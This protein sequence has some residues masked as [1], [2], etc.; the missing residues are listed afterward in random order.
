MIISILNGFKLWYR[1]IKIKQS[2]SYFL[3]IAREGYVGIFLSLYELLVLFSPIV[4]LISKQFPEVLSINY[5]SQSF[6]PRQP[7]AQTETFPTQH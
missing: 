6:S 5:Q 7:S 2:A 3:Q 4:S 1:R